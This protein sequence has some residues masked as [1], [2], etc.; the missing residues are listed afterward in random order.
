MKKDF[1]VD[2]H[3][4]LQDDQFR[5][6]FSNIIRDAAEKKVKV[7]LVPGIDLKTSEQAVQMA[8]EYLEVYAAVGVHP[9]EVSKSGENYLQEIRVLSAKEKV[10]A[11]GEIGLDFYYDFSPRDKQ[12]TDFK[13]QIKLALEIDYPMIIHMRESTIE[14]FKALHDTGGF[15]G[16]GVFH[17]FPGTVEEAMYVIGHGFYIS[18]PGIITF[19]NA[20]KAREVVKQI[21]IERLL[22]ETDSPYMAPVPH[23]GKRNTPEFIP[24]L[25]EKI[26]EVRGVTIEDVMRITTQN[27]FDLFKLTI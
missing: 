11:I 8:A 20:E 17:C 23:R 14:T 16:R 26:A 9:H 3:C 18:L 19:K 10:L 4:H 15:E 27:F 12:I 2:S 21:P 13:D 5:G 7:L 25:A 24:L 22:L 6:D 1:Y